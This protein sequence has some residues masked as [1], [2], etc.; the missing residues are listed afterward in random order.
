MAKDDEWNN[1]KLRRKLGDKVGLVCERHI[2]LCTGSN[3]EPNVASQTWKLLGK[4][5]KQLGEEGRYFHRT[6]AKCLKLCRGGP[7]ALVYPEGVYYH[8]V[9]P[10]VC[11]RLIEEHLL[12]S[13]VVEEYA[14]ARVPLL[15]VLK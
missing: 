14:F 13:R 12:N 5:F 11:E 8:S 1:K 7:I 3:C 4:R 15:D 6:E 10:E 9:T 2:L